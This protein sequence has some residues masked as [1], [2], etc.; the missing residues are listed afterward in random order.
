MLYR[1]PLGA[2]IVRGLDAHDESLVP[3]RHVCGR[4]GLHVGK[5]VFEFW[6]AHAM[7][8]DVEEGKHARLGT[9]DDA[10]LKVLEVA[11]SS[12]TGVGHSRH[13]NAERESVRIQAVVPAVGAALTSAGENM[14][15]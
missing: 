14:H 9:V 1:R 2:C 7:A 12:A 8:D 5:I 10:L 15:I 11:P 3:Q 6:A 4:L 13:S